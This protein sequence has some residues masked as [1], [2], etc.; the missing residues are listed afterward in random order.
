MTDDV[1]DRAREAVGAWDH[2]DQGSRQFVPGVRVLIEIMRGLLV[3]LDQANAEVEKWREFADDRWRTTNRDDIDHKIL[4]DSL[5]IDIG[6]GFGEWGCQALAEAFMS[7]GV[8]PGNTLKEV[9]DLADRNSAALAAIQHV[10]AFGEGLRDAGHIDAV[11]W[12]HLDRV[13]RD[14]GAS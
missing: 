12:A 3:E 13:L 1:R 10:R 5:A 8:E 9:F 14:G 4:L 6:G 11:Q 2:F 7:L